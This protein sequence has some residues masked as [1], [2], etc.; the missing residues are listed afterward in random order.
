MTQS[1]GYITWILFDLKYNWI[2]DLVVGTAFLLFAIFDLF[3]FRMFPA[4][5]NIFI[6]DA[7]ARRKEKQDFEKIKTT[8][9]M[10]DYSVF[11]RRNNKKL[12]VFELQQKTATGNTNQ[13]R[14]NFTMPF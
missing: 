7:Q 14:I 8:L 5:E 10:D 13:F 2:K 12:T 1:A 9:Q 11:K 6:E 4:Q 3:Y